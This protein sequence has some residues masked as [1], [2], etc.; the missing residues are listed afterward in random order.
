MMQ[1]GFK[2]L[3]L[4]FKSMK[5]GI[6]LLFIIMAVSMVGTVIPQGMD[7]HL[8]SSNYSPAVSRLILLLG[9][10]NI[11]NSRVFGTL[12][13]MLVINLTMCSI[14]RFGKIIKKIK[15][16]PT[17]ESMNLV[18]VES[19]ESYEQIE[20]TIEKTF[21]KHGFNRYIQDKSKEDTYYSVK[22]K[23]GYFGSWLLHFGILLVIVFYAYGT[24]TY[25]SE[26]V[27]GVPGSVQSI[28]GTDYKVRINDFN[29]EYGKD[30]AVQQYT[31]KIE[32]MD[33]EGKILK[34]SHVA[35]NKP[36]RFEGYNF[37]QTGYGW[38][39]KCN[40]SKGGNSIFQETIY[41]G[42]SL[43]VPNEN[44]AIYFNKF[45]PDF[46]AS[47]D[48]FLSLTDQLN[49]P[50]ALYAVLYMGNVVKMD[51]VQ[52]GE[53]VGW[54]EYEFIFNSPL[55]YTYLQVNNMNGQLGAVLGAMLIILGLMF[56]FFFKPKK[57]LI[58][59]ED[60]KLYVL[61]NS[62]LEKSYKTNYRKEKDIC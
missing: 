6:A 56:V 34:T 32:L 26:G 17:P 44:I 14:S 36:M 60:R 41:E 39:A 47:S 11:Y 19:I 8:Y 38:T 31:S 16:H 45:Y 48:G 62:S 7:E 52:T 9:F 4:F 1:K 40:V 30:G 46:V 35:V 23:A 53:Q 29:I 18:D 10:N 27:Y 25:F 58:Y 51:L 61:E 2:K 42:T 55:R 37:Y 28:G 57:M 24:I 59:I 21:K 33:S 3:F 50:V 54:N 5:F 15:L 49:N 22:N 12:F 43:I 20:N 13:F